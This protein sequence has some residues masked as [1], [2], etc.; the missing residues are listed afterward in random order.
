MDLSPGTAAIAVSAALAAVM[1][2]L[3]P[4]LEWWCTSEGPRAPL[5][6]PAF[7]LCI[8][9]ALPVPIL[10]AAGKRLCRAARSMQLDPAAARWE[11]KGQQRIDAL[12]GLALLGGAAAYRQA[13]EAS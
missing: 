6:A 11:K 3:P 5:I 8:L 13:D 7:C 1:T 2:V 4:P 12:S 9:P 10:V